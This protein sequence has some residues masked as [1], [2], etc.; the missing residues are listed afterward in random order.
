MAE[1]IKAIC[2]LCARVYKTEVGQVPPDCVCGT[3]SCDCRMCQET[4]IDLQ[5]GRFASVAWSA[6]GWSPE[7]G[8]KWNGA[9]VPIR[10]ENP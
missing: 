3:E 6:A 8:F 10:R 5:E 4:L 9:E 1:T 7:G 2:G